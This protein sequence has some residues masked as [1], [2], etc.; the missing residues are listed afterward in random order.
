MT[1]RKNATSV[2]V[3][4]NVSNTRDDSLGYDI[5]ACCPS[6]QER[7]AP[8]HQNA[9]N[10]DGVPK[11]RQLAWNLI[12]GGAMTTI[13]TMIPISVAKSMTIEVNMILFWLKST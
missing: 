10:I 13:V 9:I 5:S 7:P 11:T 12:F 8:T 2:N 1:L 3:N 4:K 6:Y